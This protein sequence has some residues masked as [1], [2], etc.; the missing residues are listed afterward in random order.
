MKGMRDSLGRGEEPALATFAH[1]ASVFGLEACERSMENAGGGADVVSAV[2]NL[3]RV[4]EVAICLGPEFFC[5][6]EMSLGAVVGAGKTGVND[7]AKLFLSDVCSVW[8]ASFGTGEVP[9]PK[10]GGWVSR[11]HP[12]DS[13]EGEGAGD[14][15]DFAPP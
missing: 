7:V 1:A 6:G 13:V 8:F 5:H 10:V 15:D 11:G 12:V 4:F 2:V 14:S 3:Y 9:L